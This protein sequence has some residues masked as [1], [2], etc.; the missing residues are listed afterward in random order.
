MIQL[1]MGIYPDTWCCDRMRSQHYWNGIWIGY[2]IAQLF[3]LLNY[4]GVPLLKDC[5]KLRVLRS[6]A[7]DQSSM[8][9]H[10][11]LQRP[12]IA[13]RTPSLECP[14]SSSPGVMK[15][16]PLAP[17]IWFGKAFTEVQLSN[18][19]QVSHLLEWLLWVAFC[20][21]VK[22]FLCR[23]TCPGWSAW[24]EPRIVEIVELQCSP[25]T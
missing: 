25:V 19:L 8:P 2:L 15:K 20:L 18:H 13:L 11:P 14:N 12:S 9:Q 24:A 6:V 4:Y 22:R 16:G 17:W 10:R 1:T 7:L 5:K 21:L 3:R 23:W